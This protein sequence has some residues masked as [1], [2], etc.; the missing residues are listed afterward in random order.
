M[1]KLP[2]AFRLLLALAFLGL[3]ALSSAAATGVLFGRVGDAVTGGPLAGCRVRVF[4]G[5]TSVATD[6]TGRF[7]LAGLAP[8]AYRAVFLK[9]GYEVFENAKGHLCPMK[10][11]GGGL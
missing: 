1:K 6:S 7:R 4:P 8:G 3:P 5:D 10:M 11:F 9:P 2:T